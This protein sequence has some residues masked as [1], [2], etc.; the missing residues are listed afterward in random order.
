[1]ADG[2]VA[3]VRWVGD[4]ANHLRVYCQ[5]SG[6]TIIEKCY[7]DGE[8]WTAGHTF[9]GVINGTGIAATRSPACFTA[10][11]SLRWAGR[12]IP[13]LACASTSRDIYQAVIEQCY[14]GGKRTPG[15]FIVKEV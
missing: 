10:P 11:A 7:D 13:T 9:G 3:A 12:R 8:G 2:R 14:G 15:V 5:D 4:S 1:M 6:N